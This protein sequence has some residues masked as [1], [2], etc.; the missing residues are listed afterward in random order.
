MYGLGIKISLL[1]FIA[2]AVVKGEAE[3]YLQH[4]ACYRQLD[5]R[6]KECYPNATDA[7][8]R[9]IESGGYIDRNVEDY[10]KMCL[11]SVQAYLCV[12]TEVAKTCGQEAYRAYFAMGKFGDSVKGTRF[13]CSSIDFEKELRTGFF[14]LF[15]INP[16]EAYIYNEVLDYLKKK[17]EPEVYEG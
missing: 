7:L 2:F 10:H 8:Q 15:Q 11:K 3:N 5:S 6:F 17:L 14:S 13:S 16:N 4:M 9:Y 12:T 1:F